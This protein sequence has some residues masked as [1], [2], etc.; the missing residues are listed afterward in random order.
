MTAE[1]FIAALRR[2]IARRGEVK[3]MNSDNGTNFVAANRL[4]HELTQKEREEFNEEVVNEF[5]S[6]GITW[7]FSPPRAP[8]FNGL[9]EAGVKT[10]KIHFK[11]ALGDKKFTFEELSTVLTQIEAAVN[12]RPL[13]PM[14][15]D[16]N[17]NTILTPA[18]FLLNSHPMAIASENLDE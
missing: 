1:A 13:I 11:K 9:V 7:K 3:T 16:P 2:F 4:L 6:Q 8:H 18:H 15:S 14:S 5:T 17:D 12:S 10:I